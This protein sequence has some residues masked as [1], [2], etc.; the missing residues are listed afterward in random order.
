MSNPIPSNLIFADFDDDGFPLAIGRFNFRYDLLPGTFY[1]RTGCVKTCYGFFSLTKF[2]EGFEVLCDGDV[3]WKPA[4]HGIA[5]DYSVEG[6][7]S[8]H[9]DKLYIGKTLYKGKTIIGKVHRRYSSMYFPWEEKEL[10]VQDNYYQLIDKKQ[11][12]PSVSKFPQMP[13]GDY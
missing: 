6:G 4:K 10:S 12:K 8:E 11:P 7:F 9:R 1:I 2:N 13:Y 5:P 3:E